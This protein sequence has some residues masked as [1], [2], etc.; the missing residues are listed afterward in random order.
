MKEAADRAMSLQPELGEA[1]LAQGVYRYRVLRDFK[2]ALQS[3]E[4]ALRRLPNSAFVLQQMA[5]LE[6]RLGQADVA[7]KHYQAAARLDPRNIGILLTLADTFQSVRR[8]DEARAILDRALEM[9]PGNE[10]ALGL[11][12]L[13]FQAEGRLNEAAENLAKAP[14]NS[15]DEAVTFAR[16]AQFYYE[17]RF[18]EA[19][20][21]IQQH[22]PAEFANDPRI[23]TLP[24]LLS[25]ICRSRRRGA[26]YLY[27]RCCSDEANA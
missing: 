27:A 19:I 26:C 20:V 25:E 6:R 10:A 7:Q 14:A 22:T 4:E 1:W 3:Y 15:Q 12:A 11:K 24:R 9:A 13:T 2:G 21:Q 16:A 17:R 18:D 8:Y 23:M 5:H